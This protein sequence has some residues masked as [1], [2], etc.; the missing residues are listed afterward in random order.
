MIEE[1]F[2]RIGL[3]MH[4]ITYNSIKN[5]GT[6]PILTHLVEVHPRNTQTKCD[7][8]AKIIKELAKNCTKLPI[9]PI[10]TNLVGVQP[11]EHRHKILRQS[12]QWFE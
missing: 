7:C 4:K 6:S 5:R 10:V 1:E 3:K 11:K 8:E 12:I 2:L 9:I